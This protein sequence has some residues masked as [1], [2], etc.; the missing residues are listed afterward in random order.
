MKIKW[1]SLLVVVVLATAV[2]VLASGPLTE[3]NA[4]VLQTFTGEQI[5]DAF[6]WV[7]ADLGDINGDGVHDVIIPAPFYA[8]ESGN[9]TGKVYVYSGADG[10]LLHSVMGNGFEVL[11]YSAN[12]A[13]DVNQDGV[14]DYA[15]GGI[16]T[17]H[18]AVYSGANHTVLFDL[19]GA[20]G[21]RFGS[22]VA[23]AGD[24]NG[25]GYA[26][27]L[28]GAERA[29]D[30]FFRA[31]RV[32]L[33]SGYDGSLL[34][35][36]GGEGASYLLGS[37]AG[38][39][40]DVTGDGVPDAVFGA[41]GAPGATGTT[42]GG[43]AYVFSGVDGAL[44][45]TLQ[46]ENT[47]VVFGQF[48]ASGAGDVDGDGTPD[49]FVADY[50]DGGGN[51]RAYVFSGANGRRIL[52]VNGKPGDGLGP[53]RGLGDINGDGYSDLIVAAYTAS[54][55]A[56]FAGKTIV[57]SGR[58]RTPLQTITGAIANDNL[59]VDALGVGDINGDGKMDFLVTAVGNNFA[60]LDVGR[61]YIVAGQ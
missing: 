7:A 39:V 54:R 29:S 45:Y 32:Y 50:A 30:T 10:T 49:I 15:I 14:P 41:Y 28:V 2:S 4:I 1:M 48:F 37:A 53:R 31:G 26:D 38:S 47:A 22:A 24:V 20:G 36:V 25:D 59:G 5:G 34:W 60:G 43:R 55:G 46:P 23:P 21:D 56:P 8:D 9:L 40:G 52:L 13:G 51:G 12:S 44:V 33:F 16:A 58:D 57:I 11:G 27:L 35:S 6:G 3:P 18:V 17:S 19:Y 42:S 61:A